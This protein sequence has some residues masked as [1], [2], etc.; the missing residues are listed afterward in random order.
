MFKMCREAD[1]KEPL[2]ISSNNSCPDRFHVKDINHAVRLKCW[3]VGS[4]NRKK[5]KSPPSYVMTVKWFSPITA[6]RNHWIELNW[7]ENLSTAPGRQ[8]VST[9]CKARFFSVIKTIDGDMVSTWWQRMD[10]CLNDGNMAVVVV[11]DQKKVWGKSR[12]F[13]GSIEDGIVY[14]EQKRKK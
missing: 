6:F 7:I 1:H 9:D 8:E 13:D 11:F 12:V 10:R 5:E 14:I 3:N 4:E 2:L